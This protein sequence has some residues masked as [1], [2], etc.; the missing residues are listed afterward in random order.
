MNKGG[1][2]FRHTRGGGGAKASLFVPFLSF[3]VFEDTTKG[4]RLACSVTMQGNGRIKQ[5][6]EAGRT[7]NGGRRD[8]SLILEPS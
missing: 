2:K 8:G 3:C 4:L 5:G 7:K 6:A 1:T